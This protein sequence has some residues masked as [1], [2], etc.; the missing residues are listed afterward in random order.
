MKQLVFTIVIAF[1]MVACSSR[2]ERE[3]KNQP[4][5]I[6]KSQIDLAA[7]DPFHIYPPRVSTNWNCTLLAK[8]GPEDDDVRW[9]RTKT[10]CGK[11]MQ[12]TDGREILA[13]GQIVA[14]TTSQD[15]Y[16]GP[17]IAFQSLEAAQELYNKLGY[18]QPK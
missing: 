2:E 15:R 11:P 17:V 10:M 13:T 12:I 8:T 4:V 18:R 3:A 16:M 9:K 14:L 7:S 5:S 6:D 1:T